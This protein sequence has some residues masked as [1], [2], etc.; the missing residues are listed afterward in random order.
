MTILATYQ[1]T[2]KM[3]AREFPLEE[4]KMCEWRENSDGC[5]ETACGNAFEVSEGTPAENGMK[6]CPY[7]GAGLIAVAFAYPADDGD[8]H[9]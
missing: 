8:Y 6:F 1:H 4:V 7:C 9:A 5:W 3:T 2:G